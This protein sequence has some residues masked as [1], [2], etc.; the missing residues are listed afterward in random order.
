MASVAAATTT[1]IATN[2]AA[3]IPRKNPRDLSGDVSD[4]GSAGC[5]QF[6]SQCCWPDAVT[7]AGYSSAANLGGDIVTEMVHKQ[8]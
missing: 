6:Y 2:S 7:T 4:A 5:M 1:R 8:K 3:I